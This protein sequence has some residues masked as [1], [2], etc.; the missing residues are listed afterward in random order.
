[1]KY[2]GQLALLC[3][4]AAASSGALA[5]TAIYGSNT[6]L[7]AV[8]VNPGNARAQIYALFPP[9]SNPSGALNH[10]NFINNVMT[11]MAIDGVTIFVPWNAVEDDT[12]PQHTPCSSPGTDLCQQDSAA[13]SYYH[14]YHWEVID[15]PNGAATPCNDT[16]LFSSYQWFCDFPRGSGAFKKVNFQL[17]GLGPSGVAYTPGYVTTAAWT[18]A[19]NA[20]QHVINAVNVGTTNCPNA[21]YAGIGLPLHS[22]WTGLNQTPNSTISVNWPKHPFFAGD[23]IWVSGFSTPFTSFNTGTNGAVIA[24]QDADDF[25]YMGTGQTSAIATD[26]QTETAVSANQSWIVPYETPYASAYEAFLKAAIYHFNHLNNVNPSNH[27]NQVLSQ[28]AYIRPGIAKRGEGLPICT[29]WLIANAGYASD[30]STWMNWFTQ[31]NDAVMSANPQM[32][33]MLSINTGDP[34]N[35]DATY[36]T[37]S[38]AIAVSH[39]NA[40]GMFNGFGSQGLAQTDITNPSPSTNLCPGTGTPTTGNNWG[41]MFLKYWSGASGTTGNMT[42]SPT[43]VPLELQQIDCSNPTGYLGN[44]GVVGTCFAG[45]HLPGKTGDLRTL[46]PFVTSQIPQQYSA[47]ATIL[48]LYSQDALL[49]FDPKFCLPDS[50]GAQ[51]CT[52]DP[53][54]DWFGTALQPNEQY[55][56]YKNVGQGVTCNGSC[57]ADVI[58]AV[59]GD[60]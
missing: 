59:H 33:I 20:T 29:T 23:T 60:K 43:T 4:S 30:G 13:P 27:V 8:T 6:A 28:I 17:F 12:L 40:A 21:D 24:V 50:G 49:A 56:F 5:Q 39:V 54:Y 47:H 18:S 14:T 2:L 34:Q 9:Q 16:T 58:R 42:A 22:T 1:M 57:Y 15:G 32:Q 26:P 36:A 55:N 11:Q 52:K 35:Q 10:D 46:Y 51:V 19:V 3:V 25:S 41:C 48:E 38:A 45:Q 44:G 37:R 31:V 53:S 7:H